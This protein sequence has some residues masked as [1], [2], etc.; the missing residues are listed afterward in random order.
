MVFCLPVGNIGANPAA[1]IV[2]PTVNI[3]MFV[4]PY[5]IN[6]DIDEIQILKLNKMTTT[7]FNFIAK[8]MHE[9]NEAA[10]APLK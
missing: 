10:N 9:N 8:N 6:A 7:G 2:A 5:N 3:E 1:S 4:V